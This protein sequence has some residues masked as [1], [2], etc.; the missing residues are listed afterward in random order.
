M[1]RSS[2]WNRRIG[3][4][5]DRA[6]IVVFDRSVVGKV[7]VVLR[8]GIGEVWRSVE[9]KESEFR[10]LE[11]RS[12]RGRVVVKVWRE[13]IEEVGRLVMYKGSYHLVGV[14]LGE[15]ELLLVGSI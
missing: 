12:R 14:G 3:V 4:L 11:G 5:L 7:Q 9:Y 1:G 8:S 15:E 10:R 2:I 13:Y 6:S